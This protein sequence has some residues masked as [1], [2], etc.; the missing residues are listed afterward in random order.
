MAIVAVFL[1][2]VLC[3]V[4]ILIF[5]KRPDGTLRI[6]RSNPEKDT[7]RIEIDDLE[8]LSKKR[9]VI[10]RVDANAHLSHE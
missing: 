9:R 3:S 1:L 7:Y 5:L 10:L 6:D 8:S 4:V 2:G